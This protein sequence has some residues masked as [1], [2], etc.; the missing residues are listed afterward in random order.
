M[1]SL[2]ADL[3]GDANSGLSQAGTSLLQH[4]AGS[5]DNLSDLKSQLWHVLAVVPVL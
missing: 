3:E 4:T 5:N 2:N 1:I